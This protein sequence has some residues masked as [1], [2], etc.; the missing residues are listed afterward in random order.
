MIVNFFLIL[1]LAFSGCNKA[2]P[3]SPNSYKRESGSPVEGIRIAW[4]Y[5]SMQKLAPQ[6]QRTAK[7]AGY[8][9]IRKLKNGTLMAVYDIDGNGEMVQSKDQGKTWSLPVVTFKYHTYTNA[10]NESTDVGIANSELCQLQN[11]DLVMACNYR[12]VKDEIA[13]FAIAIRRSSDMGQS[14]S[15]DQVIFEAKQR[16]TDGCWEPSILQLPGSELQVYF[17][18]ESAFTATNEQNIS[19]L[20]SSDNG[21]TWSKEPKTV[22]F[23]ANRRD[24]MPVALLVDDEILV[25][26]EDNNIG[27]FKP[28]LVRTKISDNW[29]SPVLASSSNR[30]YA[31]KT[32]LK[33]D[34]YAGAPYIMRIPSG[35]VVLS[36]QTTGD[37]SSDWELSTME[38]AIGDTKGRNFEKLSRPFEVPMGREAKWNSVSLW[39]ER[40]IVAASTTSFRSPNCEAWIISGHII[41]EIQASVKSI[42]TD[43]IL[44]SGEWGENFPIFIG[45]KS[46]VNLSSSVCH[47]DKNLYVSVDVKDNT[48]FTDTSDPL[49][50]DGVNLYMDAGNSSLVSP[51]S[52]IYK[53]WCNCKG[54]TKMYE[55]GK[56]QWK[57]I[58]AGNLQVKTKTNGAA[59]YRIE[60]EI[61]FSYIGKQDKSDMR[62][63]LG[64][65]EYSSVNAFYEENIANSSAMESNTW[66]RIKLQ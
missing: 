28:Y 40:T 47:D 18:N 7:W 27:Q 29:S 49:K 17:A 50:S 15:E 44:S 11:G 25:S 41:P 45:H 14:W 62:L 38:V 16:F 59:G 10:K 52:G 20:S 1:L 56:G 30:E 21:K 3:D 22:S 61:P 6:G 43:G 53:I 24:G 65:V 8:P 5:S 19:M 4:D 64:M 31:L 46:E 55:G 51:D 23:R 60:F 58:Q 39:D 66:L 35:E 57:E 33:D 54:L 36:Y 9:R 26:I 37:R 2:E 12:P 42:V 63:N 34:I 32:Q 48:L 13:P